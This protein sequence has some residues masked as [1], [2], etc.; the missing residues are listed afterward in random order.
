MLRLKD[1]GYH[2]LINDVNAH[3]RIDEKHMRKDQEASRVFTN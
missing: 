3:T 1:F 2:I